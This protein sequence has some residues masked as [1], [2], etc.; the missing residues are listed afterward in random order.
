[1]SE[2]LITMNLLYII[3]AT[4]LYCP[5]IQE[6]VTVNW[7]ERTKKAVKETDAGEPEYVCNQAALRCRA[8]GNDLNLHCIWP[9]SGW[10]KSK[11]TG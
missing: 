4:L 8:S 1:M 10:L 11:K 2:R 5:E 9:L 7:V 3:L 6:E